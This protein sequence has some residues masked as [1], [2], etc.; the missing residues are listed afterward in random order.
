M[1]WTKARP[2]ACGRVDWVDY[3]KGW[4]IILVVMMHAT[5]G[6]ESALGQE[7]WLNG[8]I[9]WARPFRMPDFFLVAGLFLSRSIDRPWRD[10]LDRKVLHFAYF[11]V[12]WT[13]IQGVPKSLWAGGD[14]ISVAGDLAFAM[15]EPFGTLWF[16]YLLPIFF[17][18]TK[19]LRR[20]APELVLIAAAALQMANIFTDWTVIDEFAARYVYF[21]AGYLFAPEIFALAD[22]ARA[23]VRKTLAALLA[24][25]VLNWLAVRLGYAALPGV[26]LALGFAGACAVVAFSAL[27]ARAR[28]FGFLPTLGA[29]SIIVYLAFFLPMAATRVLLL[30]SGLIGDAGA[31]SLIVTA[32]AILVPLALSRFVR[33]TP[34]AFLFERPAIFRLPPHPSGKQPRF[35][36]PVDK[37]GDGWP[38]SA[39]RLNSIEL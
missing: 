17:V 36:A 37:C 2:H 9:A 15:I 23:N 24:W 31:V 29:R 14:A 35:A 32:V 21:F 34:L 39:N 38:M 6:V 22:K 28:I 27:L 30:K 5:Y 11:F 33:G 25:G 1:P 13:L 10:Y 16:I 4:C 18:A 19:L 3:A 12:L 8:F 7:S 26:S 20:A